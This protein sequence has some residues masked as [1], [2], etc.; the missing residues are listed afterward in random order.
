MRYLCHVIDDALVP[1]RADWLNRWRGRDVWVEVH[2]LPSPVIRSGQSNRKLWAMYNEICA[3]TGNDPDT[4]H[5]ALKSEAVRLG[6]LEPCYALI[7]DQLV[8]DEATTVVE[9]ESFSRYMD[10][11]RK[12]SFDKLN[13]I[14]SE[15]GE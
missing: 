14:L 9:Q 8:P 1:E 6:V 5:R 3:E 2:K 15:S 10:F 11:V 13:L 4:V 12:W 7:G